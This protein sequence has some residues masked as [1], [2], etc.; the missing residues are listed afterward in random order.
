MMTLIS[1]DFNFKNEGERKNMDIVLTSLLTAIFILI[2]LTVG[3]I[4][5]KWWMVILI[6][7]FLIIWLI[8]YAISGGTE[9]WLLMIKRF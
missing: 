8:I 7:A 3:F 6:P 1:L 2:M 4:L 9:I 5:V